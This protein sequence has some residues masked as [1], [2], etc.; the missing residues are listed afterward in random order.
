MLG[1]SHTD[2]YRSESNGLH[3]KLLASL[4]A[5]EY[6][7]LTPHLERHSM[8]L[9]Q[10]LHKQGEPIQHVFFPNGGACSLVKTL[11]DGQT[12]EVATIGGEGAI[13]TGVF[14]GE[15]IAECEV[16]VQIPG[17]AIDSMPADLF[18]REM[19]QHG[20]FFNRVIRYN[21][22]LLSQVMQ[23]TVCN[24]LH[25]AEQRCCRWLLMSHDRATTDQFALTHELMAAMLGVRRPTVTLVMAGLQKAGL[26]D[27]RRGSI[28]I[29][30]KAGLEAAACECY[31][32]VRTTWTRLLPEVGVVS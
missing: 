23:T 14:F 9:R 22:A 32:A 28:T 19:E 8:R 26:I 31:R 4:P 29:L 16:I 3:N 2:P 12:A 15:R 18:N 25:S 7:R 6:Q 17:S 27:H 20:A 10:V 13:G 21:Q 24:G 30:D 1:S 11:H 5:D